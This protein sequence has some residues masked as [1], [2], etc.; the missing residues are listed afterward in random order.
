M[1]VICRAGKEH[2]A[3][4]QLDLAE[5]WR[6]AGN[7]GVEEFWHRLPNRHL[8]DN[9]IQAR[10]SCK[11]H[12]ATRKLP[13]LSTSKWLQGGTLLTVKLH[14][15]AQEGLNAC[16]QQGRLGDGLLRTGEGKGSTE[17]IRKELQVRNEQQRS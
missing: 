10:G 8:C 1:Q 2:A 11:L 9:L 4:K 12:A 15:K 3:A 13:G 14:G 5:K 7:K 6:N 16:S 17:T